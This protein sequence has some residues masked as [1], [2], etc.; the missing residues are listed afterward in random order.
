MRT[1]QDKKPPWDHLRSWTGRL[2]FVLLSI[3]ILFLK[4]P[5]F[6]LLSA[7]TKP[8]SVSSSLPPFYFQPHCSLPFLPSSPWHAAQPLPSLDPPWPPRP[9]P[10]LRTLPAAHSQTQQVHSHFSLR[11]SSWLLHHLLLSYSRSDFSS[12]AYLL[13]FPES[14]FDQVQNKNTNRTLVR[15]YCWKF[16]A[17]LF[18][19]N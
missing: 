14:P 15:E 4:L 9:P 13:D 10:H 2:Q 1:T 16:N 8:V 18:G 12:A 5:I 11:F 19:K 6:S 3:F 7:A 17:L